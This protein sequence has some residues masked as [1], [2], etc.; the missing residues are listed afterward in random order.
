MGQDEKLP[1]AKSLDNMTPDEIIEEIAIGTTGKSN[2]RRWDQIKFDDH[3]TIADVIGM[4]KH[5]T[6]PTNKSYL[7]RLRDFT[8]NIKQ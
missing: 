7:E 6:E 5:D 4:N 1:D 3:Q 8:N 2:P